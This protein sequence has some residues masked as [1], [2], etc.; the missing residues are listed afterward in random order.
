[1]LTDNK[2]PVVIIHGMWS[3]AGTMQEVRDAF[4]S[5]GYP[6]EAV[7]L[8]HHGP[9]S[10]HTDSSR[11]ALEG[12]SLQLYVD[13][14][15]DHL[16]KLGRPPILVGHSMGGL[17]AQL[18]AARMPCERL[19]LLSSAAPAG[20]NGLGVS[21][22][23]TLGTNLLRFPLWKRI[24]ELK[25]AN[26][27]YGIANSQSAAKQQEI[28]EHCGYES[29]MVTFQMSVAAFTRR[30]FA[31][32]PPE[33]IACPVLIIGG[34]EDRVTPIRIQRNLARRYGDRCQLVEIPGCC[35]WTIGG[36]F[37]GEVSQVMFDWLGSSPQEAWREGAFEQAPC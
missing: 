33:S 3:D 31:D 11:A 32:V 5:Q 20:I 1:M 19:I 29:G 17:L 35:H 13:F 36:R 37:F 21:V 22:I 14:L 16:R 18:T 2:P 12:A 6:V 30:V 27:K 9:R 23:R 34:T 15:M 24:T 4:V 28:F 25:L 7:T 10:E 8:P 26:V